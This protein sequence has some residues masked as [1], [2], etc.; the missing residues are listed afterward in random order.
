[1]R[2]GSIELGIRDEHV[3]PSDHIA[4]LWE[5]PEEFTE[6]IGFLESGLRGTDHCVIFGH[7]EA[8]EK[9][10]EILGSRGFDIDALQAAGRLTILSGQAA[11]HSMLNEIGSVF[12]GAIARGASLI[13]L[14]GNI[15]WG[16][17]DWPVE[18]DILAFEANVTGAAKE[19]PC[20]VVCMYDVRALPSPV[21]IHGAFETHPLTICGNILRENPYYRRVDEF[22]ASLPRD[23]PER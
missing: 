22:I 16:R 14:L 12:Q 7:D 10:Y 3:N 18:H 20:V 9:V 21:I 6:G 19:F 11:G 13:R 15:G 8:N 2:T 23:I 17:P 5:T 4:Y 1:M